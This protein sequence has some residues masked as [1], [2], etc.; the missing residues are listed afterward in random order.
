[1]ASVMKYKTYLI[2]AGAMLLEGVLLFLFLPSRAPTPAS[3]SEE[4]VDVAAQKVEVAE[5]QVGEFKVNNQTDPGT[6]VRVEFS[7][8]VTVEAEKKTEFEEAFK[9]KLQR[10]REA[11]LVVARRASLEELQEHDLKTIK[12]K[13]KD[14]MVQVLG[15]EKAYM[16]G[17]VIPDFK[18][19]E[20]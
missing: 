2:L 7:V 13:I 9:A 18:P 19:Q 6:P 1:M 14:A 8:Y 3:A 16:D 5:I 11:V 4:G 15:A 12:R 17:V 10:I 20:L